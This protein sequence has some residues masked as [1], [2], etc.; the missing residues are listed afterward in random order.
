MVTAATRKLKSWPSLTDDSLSRVPG[1]ERSVH[2]CARAA[3]M[4]NRRG[5]GGLCVI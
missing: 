4:L 1:P 3:V 5:L 2:V